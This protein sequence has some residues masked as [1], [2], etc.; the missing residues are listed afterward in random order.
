M[1]HKIIIL[2]NG[3]VVDEGHGEGG[4]NGGNRQIETYVHDHAPSE[5]VIQNPSME[6]TEKV[7]KVVKKY[8]KKKE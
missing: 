7:F 6:L 2:P 4:E 1:P 3:D 5:I 8:Y